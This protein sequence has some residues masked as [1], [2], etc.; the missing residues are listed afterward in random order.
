[1]GPEA[2]RLILDR[3]AAM[4]LVGGEGDDHYRLRGGADPA[5]AIEYPG[6]GEDT[7]EAAG[8]FSVPPAVERA[9]AAG[10]SPVE[11]R[12][13]EGDQTLVGGPAG[14][15]LSGGPG[16]VRIRGSQRLR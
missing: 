4:S 15:R 9:V 13:A 7:V 8:R 6:D 2:T 14:D 11:I 16:N 3:D 12:A 10:D 1:V 5:R